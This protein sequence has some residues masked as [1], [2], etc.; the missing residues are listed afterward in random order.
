MPVVYLRLDGSPVWVEAV[1]APFEYQGRP[2]SLVFARDVSERRRTEE[3]KRR[4]TTLEAAVARVRDAYIAN[5]TSEAIFD[6]ALTEILRLTGSQY[7]YIA[8][9]RTEER[10]GVSQQCLAISNIAWDEETQKFYAANAPSGLVFHAM[11]GLNAAA[12]VS[13]EPVFANDPSSDPRSS[14]R[15]P[16]D[17]R[18][19]F[20]S[21][22]CLCSM[23]GNAGL[24]RPG[25]PGRRYD[26]A[27]VTSA[28]PCSRPA[29]DH[30]APAARTPTGRCQARAEAAAGKSEFRPT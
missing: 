15:L 1:S 29:P 30:R 6:A 19:S 20:L 9:L 17:I 14:G 25:Q 28:S 24:H 2:G 23:A 27:V 4:L 10:G 13:G 8:E 16:T 22:G 26:E 3:E 18:P 21:L 12:V 7:G 11:D 5:Q